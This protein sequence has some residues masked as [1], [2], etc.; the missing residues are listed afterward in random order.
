MIPRF[1]SLGAYFSLSPYFGHERKARQ[2]AAF[3][4][5]PLDRLLAETDAP[6]MWPPDALNPHPL[7]QDGKPMNHPAN[8]SVSYALLARVRGMDLQ[9][10]EQVIADNHR[11]LFGAP[12]AGIQ[13]T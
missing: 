8:L 5:V 13:S 2:L 9:A 3:A 10:L 1:A 6:D 7:E 12:D 4:A 11:R